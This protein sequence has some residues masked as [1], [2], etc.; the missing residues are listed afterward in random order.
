MLKMKNYTEEEM[1]FLDENF[2]FIP[3]TYDKLF[4]GIFKD[5]LEILKK[6]I[7]SQLEFDVN[8]DEC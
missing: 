8:P 1:I 4:K 6:F 2:K 5:N 3:L 7:L